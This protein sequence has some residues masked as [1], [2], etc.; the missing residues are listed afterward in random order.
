MATITYQWSGD[1][2]STP[3]PSFTLQRADNTIGSGTVSYVSMTIG[4]RIRGSASKLILSYVKAPGYI[5]Y[6]RETFPMSNSITIHPEVESNLITLAG[7]NA[8]QTLTCQI[9]L[10]NS[11]TSDSDKTYITSIVLAFT[12]TGDDP[13][14]GGSSGGGSSGGGSSGGGSSGGGGYVPPDTSFLNLTV[15]TNPKKVPKTG[16]KCVVQLGISYSGLSGEPSCTRRDSSGNSISVVNGEEYLF[17]PN[18]Q[19]TF[20]VTKGGKTASQTITLG[21]LPQLTVTLSADY[22]GKENQTYGI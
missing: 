21:E 7:A 9:K 2:Y 12:T 22:V 18:E 11:S 5:N 19:Y 13:S 15:S 20:T 17:M 16:G 8:S 6:G 4:V 10:Q 14:S 3:G 1:V